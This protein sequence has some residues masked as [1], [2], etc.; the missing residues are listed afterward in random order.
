MV[1]PD[2]FRDLL[3]SVLREAVDALRRST[4]QSKTPV[5]GAADYANH[6]KAYSGEKYHS[7]VPSYLILSGV[8]P[9]LIE[10]VRNIVRNNTMNG[11]AK[12]DQIYISPLLGDAEDAANFAGLLLNSHATAAAI[13]DDDYILDCQMRNNQ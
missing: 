3:L 10:N 7:I 12:T 1:E 2:H 8:H 11:P 13:L 9:S 4:Q 5:Q 6:I